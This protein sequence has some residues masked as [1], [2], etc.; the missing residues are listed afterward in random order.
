LKRTP[1]KKISDKKLASLAKAREI[2]Q[3][4]LSFYVSL[5]KRSD[6]KCS[7]S[8]VYLGEEPLTTFFHHLLPKSKYPEYRWCEWNIVIISARVHSQ[9]ETNISKVPK[10][11][12]M[13]KELLEKHYSGALQSCTYE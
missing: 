9:V 1:L 10:I 7:V 12:E 4:D 2:R 5:W 8:G 13:T 11:E 6:K 3:K